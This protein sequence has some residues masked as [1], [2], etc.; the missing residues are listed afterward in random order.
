MTAQDKL[1]DAIDEQKRLQEAL[2]KAQYKEKEL[3]QQV[4]QLKGEL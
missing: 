1:D 4:L 3:W 2:E